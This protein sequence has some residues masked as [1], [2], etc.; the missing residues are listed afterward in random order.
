MKLPLFGTLIAAS[1][2]VS[3]AL[4]PSVAFAQQAGTPP[5]NP[6]APSSNAAPTVTLD[7]RD[8][9]LR[10]VLIQLFQEAKLDYSIAPGVQG[11]VT[12]KVTEQPFE[13]VLKLVLRSA[14][15]PLTYTRSSGVYE[16]KPRIVLP[17]PPPAPQSASTTDSEPVFSGDNEHQL[18]VIPLTYLDPFDV[19][20]LLGITL[21]PN[22]TRG[23]GVGGAGQSSGGPTFGGGTGTGLPGGGVGILGNNGTGGRLIGGNGNGTGGNRRGR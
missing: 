8:A 4:A 9:P 22:G 13:T 3:A 6:P 21:L 20:Q 15:T 10:Q 16:I 23:G 11:F 19:Q 7:V 2:V 12:L 1:C 14:S 18:A 17:T 5:S